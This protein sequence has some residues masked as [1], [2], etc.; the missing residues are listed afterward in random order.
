MDHGC[1][2]LMDAKRAYRVN[3][4]CQDDFFLNGH[5]SWPQSKSQCQSI[6]KHQL[7]DLPSLS[8]CLSNIGKTFGGIFRVENAVMSSTEEGDTDMPVDVH[9]ESERECQQG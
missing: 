1:S 5:C 6:T 9:Q 8:N 4:A 7:F 2:C 3:S